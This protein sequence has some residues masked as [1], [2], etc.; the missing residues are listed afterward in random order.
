MNQFPDVRLAYGESDEYS[1]V[2][3]KSTEMYGGCT[4]LCNCAMC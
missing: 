4:C 2:V 1:F 3:C